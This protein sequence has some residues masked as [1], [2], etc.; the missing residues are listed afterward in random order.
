M[1]EY[2]YR[3]EWKEKVREEEDDG[4]VV[5]QY[6]TVKEEIRMQKYEIRNRNWNLVIF[7]SSL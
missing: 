5:F 2:I 3:I 1:G 4:I 7:L 6:R